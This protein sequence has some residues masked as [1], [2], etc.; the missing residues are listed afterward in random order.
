MRAGGGGVSSGAH[1]K[2]K[3]DQSSSGN[4]SS[5]LHRHARSAVTITVAGRERHGTHGRG[6]RKSDLG[7]CGHPE[8]PCGHYEG[9]E[10]EP[11]P[12]QRIHSSL[13]EGYFPLFIL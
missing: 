9:H 10:L 2:V 12:G 6:S 1:I 13:K 7:P 4:G 11:L 3:Q 8:G 5:R